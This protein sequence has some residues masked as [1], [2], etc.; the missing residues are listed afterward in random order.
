MRELE[1]ALGQYLIYRGFLSL[2]DTEQTIYPAIS[3]A[4]YNS[5]FQQLAIQTILRQNNIFLIVVDIQNEV[6]VEWIN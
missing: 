2:N 5:F 4:I 6:I 3:S 1:T